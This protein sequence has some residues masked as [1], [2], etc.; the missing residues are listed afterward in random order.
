MRPISKLLKPGNYGGDYGVMRQHLLERIGSYCSY[1]EAPITNDTAVEHKVAKTSKNI[2]GSQYRVEVGFPDQANDWVNL[3]LAC[4]SCNSAKASYPNKLNPY[5]GS[6]ELKN[7][8]YDSVKKT[9]IW[10]DVNKTLQLLTYQ[11]SSK[12]QQALVAAGHAR[13]PSR[14]L[15]NGDWYTTAA[16]RVWVLPND[17]F[18]ST[19]DE[20]DREAAK[21]RVTATILGL[22]LNYHNPWDMKYSDRRVDNRT[23]AWDVA[24]QCAEDLATVW[25]ALGVN[26]TVDDPKFWATNPHFRLL[27]RSIRSTA[28][29]VG[30]WSVWWTVLRTALHHAPPASPATCPICFQPTAT[31]APAPAPWNGVTLAA[32]KEILLRI[33]VE[34]WLKERTTTSQIIF[35]GTDSSRIPDLI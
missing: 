6:P 15:K 21:K 8:D 35:L 30:H 33:L 1:C 27:I 16:E 34:Y 18:I 14:W 4:Q 9:W 32:R 3:L 29:A 24:T 19:I 10:P 22:N 17:V 20:K 13:V 31:H 7:E 12:T 23:Y 5:A 28:L 2:K 26:D 25:T 11:R